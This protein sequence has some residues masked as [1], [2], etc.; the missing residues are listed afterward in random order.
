MFISK[1]VHLSIS[2]PDSVIKRIA[3]VVPVLNGRD[4]DGRP[5][6]LGPETTKIHRYLLVLWGAKSSPTLRLSGKGVKEI[7]NSFY[8]TLYMLWKIAKSSKER[9]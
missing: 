7:D 2:L 1:I 6:Y 3:R 5:K 4:S 8:F 9:R